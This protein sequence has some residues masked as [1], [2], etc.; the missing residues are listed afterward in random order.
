MSDP[1]A[2]IAAK[3][4]ANLITEAF[5]SSFK[6]LK[7][8][9]DWLV[10][11]NKKRDFFGFAARRY[12]HKVE[13][14]YNSMRIF[15]MNNPVPLRNIYTRV[16]VLNKIT[17]S[18]RTTVEDLERFFD[19]D[20]RGFGQVRE[21]DEGLKVI[22][23]FERLIILGKPGAG[24]T[25]FLKY[26]LLQALDG[27]LSKKR[28]P[29]FVGL[30]DWS[31]SN[32]DLM[33]FIIQQF[34]ICDFPDAK[35]FIH[36]ILE[37]GKCVL[38]LDG[39]D[40]VSSKVDSVIVQIRDFVDKY[41]GNQ[42]ILSCRVAA[43]S[44]CFETFS[45]VEIADFTTGQIETFIGNWFGKDSTKAKLCW[46]KIKDDKSIR[47]IASIPL[48]L[49]MLCLAFDETMDF[50][51]NRAE[52]YKEAIDALLKKWDASRSIKRDQIYRSL[53]IKRKESLFS[54]IAD[55]TFSENKYFIPQQILESLIAEF[56]TNLGESKEETLEIDSETILKSIEAQHG[57][58]VERAK[59]IYSFSHLTFQE[60]FTARHIV[61]NAT[62]GT[63]E[64]LVE[65]HLTD[66]KWREVFL[67]TT[68]ML[69]EADEFLS[70]M[71]RKLDSLI[72]DKKVISLLAAI[73][74]SIDQPDDLHALL[75]DRSPDLSY[76]RARLL[77]IG[78]N[79]SREYLSSLE[80]VGKLPHNYPSSLARGG[81]GDLAVCV[82]LAREMA[83][84]LSKSESDP[85]DRY[86]EI[87][88][89][90]SPL[91]KT[92]RDDHSRN[93]ATLEAFQRAQEMYPVLDVAFRLAQSP[94][95]SQL[96]TYLRGSTFLLR[97]LQ[98][99]CY[100]SKATRQKLV[101][102]LFTFLSP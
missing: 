59:R 67:I 79:L 22:N 87:R 78:L 97:C 19:L 18:H 45:D 3:V 65:E 58:F 40:E 98:S 23:Q 83:G 1:S 70:L 21:N 20:R 75:P 37:N 63:L 102:G 51:A 48:L 64:R 41:D 62:K 60:Y 49:T 16:N 96:M 47:E 10:R 76:E 93:L 14:R 55:V 28:I 99:E 86:K 2:D 36:R 24:K 7:E 68:G 38:L 50:P 91:S 80:R 46:Q 26:I 31:D 11:L 4:A 66:D 88:E 85:V 92:F 100:V 52:L 27:K 44:Y 101:D 13:S 81:G 8:A 73:Q 57:L 72:H 12:A 34:D 25:T 56:I 94:D 54:R 15:G 9:E 43:Y 39:F 29:I 84:T 30:K 35:N 89:V 90:F 77:T 33:D 82:G 71:R 32:I 17:S 69:D 74:R 53:S 61:D 6:S 95:L 42:F 5:K